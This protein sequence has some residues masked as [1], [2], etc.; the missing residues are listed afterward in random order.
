MLSIPSQRSETCPKC[1]RNCTAWKSIQTHFYPKK[2]GKEWDIFEEGGIKKK[3][4]ARCEKTHEISEFWKTSNKSSRDGLQIYC[5]NCF[6]KRNGTMPQSCRICGV[7]T[8]PRI[9]F[10]SKCR[11]LA[12]ERKKATHKACKQRRK[13]RLRGNGGS[14]TGAQFLELCAK[15]GNRCLGCGVV[16]IDLTVDHVLPLSKGGRNEISNIQP[17][18][19]G[20]NVRK[21]D[22]EIDF[23]GLYGAA[24]GSR[25]EQYSVGLEGEDLRPR[26]SIH[27]FHGAGEGI[28]RV[29]SDDCQLAE[30]DQPRAVAGDPGY[31]SGAV[32]TANAGG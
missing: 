28:G 1:N 11:P 4:C 22:R 23:R 6:R 18:C 14:F 5:K 20:C 30:G 3:K 17:L 16:G 7:V 15:Y 25:D 21:C 31:D 29:I 24:P 26:L 27:E 2:K 19:H 8:A 13:A 9:M 12:I 32:S 10:C